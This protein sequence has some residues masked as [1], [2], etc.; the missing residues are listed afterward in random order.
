MFQSDWKEALSRSRQ[1]AFGRL[2]QLVGATELDNTFF[3]EVERALLQADV[4]PGLTDSLLEDFKT[5]IKSRGITMADQA[6][7]EL[8]E[9]LLDHLPE[10][11][12]IGDFE[13]LRVIIVVGVNGSGKTTSVARLANWWVG[14]G[15][16][17]L[18][19]AADT[20]RAAAAEQLQVWGRRLDLDVITGQS[21]SD[22]G[23]VV[24]NSCQAAQARGRDLV[25]VDTSGRMHTQRN[26]M[27]ELE[28]II[29]V[30]GK[31]V[32]GAP[33]EVLLVLDATTGQNGLTQAEAFMAS[34]PISGMVLAKLDTSARGGT[35]FAAVEK[36]DLP[37]RYVGLGEGLEDWSKFDRVAFVEGLLAD[38]LSEAEG[39]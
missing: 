5:R 13:G 26:L 23:A 38:V 16:M 8:R 21:G 29:R 7:L 15:K 9:L 17:P 27:G 39:V 35:A 22:P 2:A 34:V 12:P 14:Q 33:H 4:G 20:Y 11:E 1:A 28:K 37:I 24:Y 32:E 30:A 3:E 19:S 6:L 36:L 25:I 18:L 10:P 31:V